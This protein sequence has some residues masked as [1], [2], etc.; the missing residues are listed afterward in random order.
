MEGCI[1]LGDIEEKQGNIN[2]ARELF[3]KLVIRV[4]W[5]DVLTLEILKKSKAI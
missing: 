5:K 4:T 1:D 3:K 2:K